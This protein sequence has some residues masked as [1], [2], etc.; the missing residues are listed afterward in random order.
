MVRTRNASAADAAAAALIQQQKLQEAAAEDY[1]G[2]FN[3]LDQLEAVATAAAAASIAADAM[4]TS[5][6]PDGDT[7]L[8]GAAENDDEYGEEAELT[9][10]TWLQSLDIMSA[11]GL[12]TP[13]CSP[14]PLVMKPPP[15]PPKPQP[16][17]LTPL[18]KAQIGLSLFKILHQTGYEF[19]FRAPADLQDLQSQE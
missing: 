1:S 7:W 4:E 19:T 11:S 10:L 6:E 5:S 9:N 3:D 12:P 2:E 14:A 15:A 18:Q 13:P 16:K 17:K 8:G